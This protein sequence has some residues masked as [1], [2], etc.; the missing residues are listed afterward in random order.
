M[1]DGGTSTSL[2]RTLWQA[3]LND[4][5]G[6]GPHPGCR[7]PRATAPSERAG[8]RRLSIAYFLR[9]NYDAQI[10]CIPA[11]ADADNPAKYAPT[12]VQEYSVSRFSQGAGPRAA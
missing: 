6:Y 7:R 10:A 5:P 8:S 3:K 11:C 1:P 12:T 2:S 9:P 4:P